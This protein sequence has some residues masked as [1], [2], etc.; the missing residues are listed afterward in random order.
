MMMTLGK[1]DAFRQRHPQVRKA[2]CL[3]EI[4][5]DNTVKLVV[6]AAIPSRRGELG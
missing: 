6:C 1:M 2:R 5:D 3:E 4:L